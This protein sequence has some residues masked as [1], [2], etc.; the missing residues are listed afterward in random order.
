VG[1]NDT[2]NVGS[3]LNITAKDSITLTTGKACIV[4]NSNGTITITGQDITVDAKGEKVVK[5][6]KNITMKGQKILQN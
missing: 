2:L 3:A 4:M 5:A 1:Q 6:A